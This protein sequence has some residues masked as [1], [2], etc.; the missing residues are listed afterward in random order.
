[1]SRP[2]RT[3]G[4]IVASIVVAALGLAFA[5]TAPAK[6]IDTY[7]PAAGGDVAVNE[8]S[9]DIFVAE[10]A[11]ERVQR[12]AADGTPEL[13]WGKDVVDNGPANVGYEI[14]Q[15]G[16]DLCKDGAEGQAKGE[17]IGNS[18][19]GIAIDQSDGSVYVW[20]SRRANDA[21]AENLRVQ[22][23]DAN[24]NFILM[25][26]K[27]VNATTNGDVCTEAS[28]DVCKAGVETS[29]PGG[30]GNPSTNE[31]GLAVSPVDGDVFAADP[32]NRRIQRFDPDGTFVGVIGSSANFGTQQPRAIAV[33][34]RGI[35]Y[36]SD[37]NS[38]AQIDRYDAYGVHGAPAFRTSI[39]A[40][41][42]LVGG[43][44]A[45]VG[46]EV[47]RDSEGDG[48][49]GADT[50]RLYV[51]RDPNTGETVVQQFDSAG[52]V[53]APAAVSA[54]HG[55]GNGFASVEG[56]GLNSVSGAL[57]VA[58]GGTNGKV[59]VLTDGGDGLP[60]I[61]A[62]LG[63]VTNIGPDRADLT[64]TIDAGGE[65]ATYRFEYASGGGAFQP[66]P[67]GSI[68]GPGE[69]FVSVTLTGLTPNAPYRVRLYAE[70]SSG[71]TSTESTL[72]GEG[73]FFTES[74][75]PEV[76]VLDP[77][78]YTDDSAW[79]A[80]RVNPNGSATTY[81]FEWGATLPYKNQVPLPEATV[82]AG[83]ETRGVIQKIEG[84]LPNTTYHYR[85]VAENSVGVSASA[86][87]TFTTRAP[88]VGFAQRAFEQV[89]PVVKN[90]AKLF[91]D[92]PRSQ[93]SMLDG[94]SEGMRGQA[95]AVARDGSAVVFSSPDV[96]ADAEWGPNYP[97]G[98]IPF[99]YQA[100][101]NADGSGWTTK[102]TVPRP[103]SM[104]TEGINGLS[105][106][107][108]LYGGPADSMSAFPSVL[109]M[110]GPTPPS[111]GAG[112][113]REWNSGDLTSLFEGIG[114]GEARF[115]GATPDFDRVY[116][117]SPVVLSSEPG[118]PPTV[119]K[120]YEWHAGEVT[121]VGID[122]S[123]T[124]FG[125]ATSLGR[126]DEKARRTAVSDDGRHVFF[127]NFPGGSGTPAG[128]NVYRRTDGETTT[129][130][131]PSKASVADPLGPKGKVFSAASDDG[132][133]VFFMSAE[134][135]T[136]D[137]NTGPT[138]SG[139]DL[140]RYEI[141]T[142]TLVD[143]SAEDNDADGARVRGILGISE[144]GEAVYYVARGQLLAGEGVLGGNNIYRW[145]DDGSAG[146]ETRFIATLGPGSTSRLVHPN[147]ETNLGA[148]NAVP[149][150]RAEEKQS[151][152]VSV[153]GNTLL[154]QSTESL[155]GYRNQGYGQVYVYEA[156]ANKGTGQLSCASCPPNGAAATAH[157]SIP[158]GGIPSEGG[159]GLARFLSDDGS[160]AFFNSEMD[161]V[162]ADTNGVQ[163]VYVWEEGRLALVSTGKDP[164][165]SFLHG[166]SASGGDAF[167]LTRERLVGQ[168]SD[169]LVDVYDSRVGGGIAQQSPPPPGE[170]CQ[171]E[172]ECRAPVD[173]VAP[174]SPPASEAFVGPGNVD[175]TASKPRRCPKGKRSVKVRG[176]T[177]CA[178]RAKKR[179]GKRQKTSVNKTNG[180]AGK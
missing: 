90:S 87:H 110:F 95:S 74:I 98:Q 64:A 143:V 104:G 100:R 3:V 17:F 162:P 33:D 60:E 178:P 140:Y 177:K 42:L 166:A 105:L 164:S 91:H 150:T 31:P 53:A 125:E 49:A 28:G 75:A 116:F 134:Q 34:S 155:T 148:D 55:A 84:L 108:E 58:A 68:S 45:T 79:L 175:E 103:P 1:M 40:P 66:L 26:G 4:S 80:A 160:R 83:G 81:R 36:A 124:P 6:T 70:K 132:D 96:F 174:I 51:L 165:P 123:G 2:Q 27:E 12:F 11:N 144:D 102:S 168:D 89:S 129:L 54:T 101:R 120:L 92:V 30:F 37:G 20:D 56:L 78:M 119:K 137:A 38:S 117:E 23:F 159:D 19:D 32:L 94:L 158:Y 71:P 114:D 127:S 151:S 15:V 63:A 180:R 21:A 65:P 73:F 135:L 109:S 170:P 14:C 138:R 24:G 149:T 122:E 147:D 46:L 9:G 8:T 111:P 156:D 112:Y 52:E 167:F 59:W 99:Y 169:G 77:H 13:I 39:A 136:D 142:D 93:G 139:N 146:G 25:F 86:D 44:G 69:Q 173:P 82:G 179:D 57:Y 88:F 62:E 118:L 115:I 76:T 106:R 172:A 41:P 10:D 43:A 35:V 48:A 67:A 61:S 176:Q 113:M 145:H 131:S 121:A 107:P 152:R 47:D 161:L 18:P 29:A 50:D 128:V 22:K 153:D 163:D 97:A 16:V 5:A 126:F 157:S 85:I 72:T 7:F 171:G 133:V 154:F 130:V 141:S